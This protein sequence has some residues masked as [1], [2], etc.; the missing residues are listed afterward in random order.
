MKILMIIEGFSVG[1]TTTSFI[2]LVTAL[3]NHTELDVTVG[4]INDSQR[5]TELNGTRIMAGIT[6]GSQTNGGFKNT[7]SR[8][9]QVQTGST[10]S[11]RIAS[12]WRSNGTSRNADID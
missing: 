4:F 2:N 5:K 3:Q 12:G 1:G 9:M 10:F 8:E 11:K 7:L 6:T